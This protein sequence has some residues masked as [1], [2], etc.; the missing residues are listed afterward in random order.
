MSGGYVALGMVYFPVFDH[1][2]VFRLVPKTL[3]S[4]Y[5]CGSFG[6]IVDSKSHKV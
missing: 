6:C 1:T 5:A 2:E 4:G 3:K